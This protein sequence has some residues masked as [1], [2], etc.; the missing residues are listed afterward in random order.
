[1]AAISQ[2]STAANFSK[3]HDA[4][5][6]VETAITEAQVAKN[7]GVPGADELLNSAKDAEQRIRNM[8]SAY[9]PGGVVEEQ[10]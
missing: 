8:L 4:L 9:F 6:K 1:M 10:P 5:G 2:F 7:A 3:L